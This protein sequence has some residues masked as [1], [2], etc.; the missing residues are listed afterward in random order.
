MVNKASKWAI[1]LGVGAT[2][3]GALLSWYLFKETNNLSKHLTESEKQKSKQVADSGTHGLE[4]FEWDEYAFI[5]KYQNVIRQ[6]AAKYDLPPSFVASV[7]YEHNAHRSY[8]QDLGDEHKVSKGGNPSL[9]PGQIRINTAMYN[10]G[11]LKDLKPSRLNSVDEKTRKF[12]VDKLND[13]EGN[14]AAVANDLARLRDLRAKQLSFNK[15]DVYSLRRDKISIALIETWYTANTS[16]NDPT[17]LGKRL[18]K[19]Y[20]SQWMQELFPEDRI[21]SSLDNVIKEPDALRVK[22]ILSEGLSSYH[23]SRTNASAK[24]EETYQAALAE[25]HKR[26]WGEG[27]EYYRSL[28]IVALMHDSKM[29]TDNKNFDRAKELYNVAL[30]LRMS[31]DAAYKEGIDIPEVVG[32]SRGNITIAETSF[33]KEKLGYVT[34]RSK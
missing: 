15:M 7:I 32:S 1:G 30:Q 31:L 10:D 22:N 28:A 3:V 16:H 12:Y 13:P 23:G 34:Q 2:L 18:L 4:S 11:L 27:K 17:S 20:G 25:E 19:V 29:Q 5:S 24:F 21:V 8:Y 9:G 6:E 26:N 33:I 14:I